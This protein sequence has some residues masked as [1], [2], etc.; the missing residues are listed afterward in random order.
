MAAPIPREAPV[1]NT[2]RPFPSVISDVPT[3]CCQLPQFRNCAGTSSGLRPSGTGE[4]PE[5]GRPPAHP[6]PWQGGCRNAVAWPGERHFRGMTGPW[7]TAGKVRVGSPP[8][9]V[10][11]TARQTAPASLPGHSCNSALIVGR[12]G[13]DGLPC[14][15]RS[16]RIRLSSG[17]LR[18]AAAKTWLRAP[19]ARQLHGRTSPHGR[20]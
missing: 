19:G 13:R 2:M 14:R 9:P 6:L 17:M 16:N 8:G 18:V 5:G 15:R 1:S 20:P 3:I 10:N 11:G 12:R 4:G 7:R